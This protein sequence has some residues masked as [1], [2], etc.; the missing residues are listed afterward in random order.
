MHDG[1]GRENRRT[2]VPARRT[3]P[4][5]GG[6]G[7][8]PLAGGDDIKGRREVRPARRGRGGGEVPAVGDTMRA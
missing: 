4:G 7:E 5:N 3:V 1:N 8:G 6:L 2:R